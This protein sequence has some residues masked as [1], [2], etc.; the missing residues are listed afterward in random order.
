[1]RFSR[2]ATKPSSPAVLF[3]PALD[4]WLAIARTVPAGLKRWLS[5]GT[6]ETFSSDAYVAELM[7]GQAIAPAALHAMIDNLDC[8]P[9]T[10]VQIDLVS[11]QPDLNAVWAQPTHAAPDQETVDALS[12][13]FKD[14]GFSLVRASSGR[15]YVSCVGEPEVV[16][17]PL[18]QIQGISL[19][20]LMPNGPEARRW[21]ALISESQILLHQLKSQGALTGGD[22]VWPWGMG[23]IPR[24]KIAAPRLQALFSSSTEF[25]ALAD[26][27]GLPVSVSAPKRGPKAGEMIE[28]LGRNDCN[29]DQNLTE[30]DI[31]LKALMRRVRWGRLKQAELATQ[32]RRWILKPK[33]VWKRV[34]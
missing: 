5:A 11:L 6:V 4:Q 1:M 17:S 24:E 28:W 30:L 10:L 31:T 29:A 20:Q 7:L 18:W 9:D 16:F 33:Q 34:G 12:D 23:Q 3:V 27:L 22:S 14:F 8:G 15:M 32:S 26:W 2:S 13:L 25:Q 19:D 21:I